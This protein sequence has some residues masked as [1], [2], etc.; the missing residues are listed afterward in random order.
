MVQMYYD[1]IFLFLKFKDQWSPVNPDEGKKTYHRNFLLEL[2]NNPAS[3]TKPEGLPS[4]VV[5][6]NKVRRELEKRI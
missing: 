5:V 2:Q 3:Q 1:L 6:L 4:L